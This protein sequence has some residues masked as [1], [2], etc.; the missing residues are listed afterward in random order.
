MKAKEAEEAIK[1]IMDKKLFGD[2]GNTVVIEEF[3]RGTEASLLC[4]VDGK[5]MISM[6]S[7]RDYKKL[8]TMT[9]DSIPEGWGAFRPTLFLMKN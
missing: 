1:S 3:L 8:M 4:F 6:E 9:R 5:N 7:A 2:A